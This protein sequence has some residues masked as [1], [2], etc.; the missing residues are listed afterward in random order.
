MAKWMAAA[1]LVGLV[2][3]SREFTPVR[4]NAEP[5]DEANGE[6]VYRSS[7]ASSAIAD[8]LMA[9]A[10]RRRVYDSCMRARGWAPN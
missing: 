2:A 7:L 9:S 6:C 8:V 3:C 4:D 1:L 10:T 5:F